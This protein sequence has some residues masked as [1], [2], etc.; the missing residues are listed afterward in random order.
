MTTVM[1]CPFPSKDL[2]NQRPIQSIR[3]NGP[4]FVTLPRGIALAH[5]GLRSRDD[6][7]R[8]CGDCRPGDPCRGGGQVAA[9]APAEGP[10]LLRAG[11]PVHPA[12]PAADQ[13]RPG[14]QI[15][16]RPA[17][18]SQ[19]GLTP[20]TLPP[21]P[22]PPEPSRSAGRAGSCS[23]VLSVPA[24]PR[25]DRSA[26]SRAARRSGWSAPPCRPS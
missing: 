2:L 13:I 15:P 22:F 18:C 5:S 23:P 21:P 14:R 19:T 25:L 11:F 8:I 9:P 16:T 3:C 17:P 20:L 6:D 10:R 12:C 1:P 7:R 26:R 4:C 24:P